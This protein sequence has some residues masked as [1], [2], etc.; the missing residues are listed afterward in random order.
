M[1]ALKLKNRTASISRNLTYSL[2]LTVITTSA[3]MIG[4]NYFTA[5]RKSGMEMERRA[6][7]SIDYLAEVLE[8]PL[9]N[10]NYKNID[11]IGRSFS[12]NDLIVNLRIID[13][14]GDVL[15]HIEKEANGAL[16]KRDGKVVHKGKHIGDI[17]LLLTSR[18]HDEHNQRLLVSSLIIAVLII[19]VLIV[20][21]GV[22]LRTFLEKPLDHLGSIADSY[23]KG[24][25]LALD[26][27]SPAREF[28]PFL[29]I[30]ER[31]GET[32]H[33][34]VTALKTSEKRLQAILDNTPSVIYMKDEEGRYVL[35]N[36]QFESFFNITRK[37]IEGKTDTDIFPGKMA[38][39]YRDNDRDVLTAGVPREFDETLPGNDGPHTFLSIKFPLIDETGKAYAL[40]GISTDITDRERA[41]ET[42]RKYSENLEKKVAVR[43]RELKEAN[44]KLKELDQLKSMFMASMSHELRTPLNSIIGFTGILLNELAGP[45]NVE[46]KKQLRMVKGSGRH[47]LNLIT[48][49]LDISKIEAGKLEI[50][51]ETF[52]LPDVIRQVAEELR[53]QAKQKGLSLRVDIAPEVNKIDSDQRRVRQVLVNLVNNAIKFTEKGE[54]HIACTGH[55][56]GIETTIRDTGIGIRDTDMDKLF[57]PFQQIDTGL[58]RKYEGTGLGLNVCKH[59]I[60]SLGGR[61]GAQSEYGKGSCFT[62]TLPLKTQETP[63]DPE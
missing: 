24:S 30:L 14:T 16:I 39:E 8:L 59:I 2:V 50:S 4:Y 11:Q 32:I 13:S 55:G 40:C 21:T 60:A 42:I 36:K 57:K 1:K 29:T 58:S 31:M 18:T 22:F 6:L 51:C 26:N 35:V 28:I 37:H 7:E 56:Q 53:P 41:K 52:N 27:G 3:L 61:I 43:T 9:W 54:V 47:L 38:A 63:H 12:Q 15:L 17:E 20:L 5:V 19:A 45:L 62:F 33:D 10:L 46:Q 49:V 48:D 34:Q 44:E 25:Y 23:S